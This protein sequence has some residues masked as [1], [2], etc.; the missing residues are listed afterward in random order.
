MLKNHQY[1]WVYDDPV[2]PILL[3]MPGYFDIIT[4]P[5]DFSTIQDKINAGTYQSVDDFKDDVYLTFR[6]TMEYYTDE[7]AQPHIMAREMMTYFDTACQGIDITISSSSNGGGAHDGDSTI[8]SHLTIDSPTDHLLLLRHSSKC[9]TVDGQ[10]TVTPYCDEMKKLW[11]HMSCCKDTECQVP[12]CLSSKNVLSHYRRCKGPCSM[13]DPVMEIT[14]PENSTDNGHSRNNDNKCEESSN[15]EE[16]ESNNEET[17]YELDVESM[18]I[19]T[20][21]AVYEYLGRFKGLRDGVPKDVVSVRVHPSIAE[22][23]DFSFRH[24]K[25]LKEVVLNEGITKI[26]DQA[27]IGCTSLESITLPSTVTEIG[28]FAFTGCKNLRNV[29]L[30]EGLKVIGNM[31]FANCKSLEIIEIPSTVAEIGKKSFMKHV[32]FVSA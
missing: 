23:E 11:K 1:G 15:N 32:I 28:V 18:T 7:D 2:D 9:K 8:I 26:G 12:H 6:N 29:S 14:R 27:F 22:V 13:C 19:N 17:D 5:M 3:G 25:H 24:C 21:D 4:N 31:A 30:N 20:S 10:C 16:E